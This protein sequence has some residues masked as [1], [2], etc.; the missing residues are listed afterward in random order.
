MTKA[1]IKQIY[2]V[3]VGTPLKPEFG[4]EYKVPEYFGH[5]KYSY[6]DL[7]K[8]GTTKSVFLSKSSQ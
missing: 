4:T 8:V 7:E 1:L 2:F 3:D 5:S 6:Y